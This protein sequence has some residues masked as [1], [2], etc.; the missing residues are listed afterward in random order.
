MKKVFYFVLSAVFAASG[1]SAAEK[2]LA[3]ES[4]NKKYQR[5]FNVSKTKDYQAELVYSATEGNAG[6][7]ACGLA[8]TNELIP[9]SSIGVYT[10]SLPLDQTKTYVCT[11]YIKP[12]K[13]TASGSFSLT[14]R[15]RDEKKGWLWNGKPWIKKISLA[16]LPADKWTK[17]ELQFQS[18]KD[19]KFWQK[20]LY[21]TAIYNV[22]NAAGITLYFDD[23]EIVEK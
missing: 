22:R 7:G 12:D 15:P 18:R 16:S 10:T 11:M 1:V 20:A 14:I 9:G 17:V 8:L 21:F 19:D 6:P 5:T 3:K 2:V 13:K 23:L 4:F